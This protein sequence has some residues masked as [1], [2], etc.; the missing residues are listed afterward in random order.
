MTLGHSRHPMVSHI[1]NHTTTAHGCQ[2]DALALKSR[3]ISDISLS[4][5]PQQSYILSCLA[6]IQNMPISLLPLL[7]LLPLQPLQLFL[8]L[9]LFL[10][11]FDFQL[12]NLLIQH[13]F[14]LHQI[15]TVGL[16]FGDLLEW[17]CFCCFLFFLCGEEV[18]L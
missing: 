11:L 12:F 5:H 2:T 17:C 1:V 16:Q 15:G 8:S 18:S 10:P 14:L 4:H 6:R 9:P 7:N 3:A 13:D